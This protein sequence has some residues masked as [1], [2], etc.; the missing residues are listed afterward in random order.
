MLRNFTKDII[1]NI[2]NYELWM[3][4]AVQ[5]TKLRYRGTI[6]GPFWISINMGLFILVLGMVYSRIF[7]SNLQE[8]L[9]YLA[10]SLIAW[11][12][13]SGFLNDAPNVF[14][15]NAGLLKGINISPI[16]V[17]MRALSKHLIVMLHN[18]LIVVGIN[19][20][21]AIEPTINILLFI[22]G[23]VLVTLNLMF[24]AIAIS[25]FGT[26][27]RD[28]GP[29]ISS[30]LQTIF[31]ITPIMWFPRL[32]P[33]DSFLLKLNPVYFFLDLIRAPLIGSQPTLQSWIVSTTTLFILF[34]CAAIIFEKTKH[35]II[36]WL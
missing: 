23:L 31:F 28:V 32:L 11:L 34:C 3:H 20:F 18:I 24:L 29:I 26:R 15:E 5:D 4:L 10:S 2:S 27:F 6:L 21:Y 30:T 8:Y 1:A 33:S 12:L 17:I 35:K 13:I 16:L 22:P 9:P 14:H 19:V 36:I 7:S 25:I